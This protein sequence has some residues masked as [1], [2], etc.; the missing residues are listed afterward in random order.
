MNQALGVEDQPKEPK[1]KLDLKNYIPVEYHEFLPLFLEALAKNLP[2]HRPYGHKI[3]LREIF[4]PRFGLLYSKS[5][6]ELQT[7]K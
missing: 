6:T 5:R 4:T 7:L 1:K 3:P 2:P